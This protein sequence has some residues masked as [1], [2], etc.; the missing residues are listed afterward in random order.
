[1]LKFVLSLVKFIVLFNLLIYVL[2]L[3]TGKSF[4][5][6]VALNVIVPAVCALVESGMKKRRHATAG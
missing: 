2:C 5:F 4:E 3:I 1:M 6:D